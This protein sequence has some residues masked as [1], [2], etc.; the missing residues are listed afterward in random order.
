MK[1]I[2]IFGVILLFCSSI[3]CDT[4]APYDFNVNGADWGKIFKDCAM[5]SIKVQSI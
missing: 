4:N 2:I 5:E 3:F 1:L